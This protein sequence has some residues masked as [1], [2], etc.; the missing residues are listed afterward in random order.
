MVLMPGLHVS[1]LTF[2]ER[3]FSSRK[4]SAQGNIEVMSTGEHLQTKLIDAVDCFRKLL[5]LT[6]PV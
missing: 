5:Y 2:A 6:D 4:P 3:P 1:M